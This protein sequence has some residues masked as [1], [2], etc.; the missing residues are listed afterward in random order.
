MT[1]ASFL[2][3]SAYLQDKRHSSKMPVGA[4]EG[5]IVVNEPSGYEGYQPAPS[6]SSEPRNM[7][8]RRFCGLTPCV[9]V[10]LI[11][12]LIAVVIGAVVGG[13]LGTR[14]ARSKSDTSN[15]YDEYT[16]VCAESHKCHQYAIINDFD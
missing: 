11:L 10:L 7:K 8:G 4:V 6:V 1:H 9:F 3:P 16:S 15:M 14:A 12:V 13:V 5:K 2:E